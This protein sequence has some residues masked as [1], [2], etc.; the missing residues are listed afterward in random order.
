MGDS[1]N[2]KFDAA[3]LHRMFSDISEDQSLQLNKYA[4]LIKEHQQRFQLV[5]RTDIHRLM[6]NH[7]IPSLIAP[8][9]I[10]IPPGITMIDIG[11]GAGLPAIPIKII[12]PDLQY[13]LVESAR[14]KTLFL[15]KT[16]ET[17][18]L[19]GI[20]VLNFRLGTEPSPIDLTHKFFIVTA[21]AV[22]SLE[23][24]FLLSQSLLIGGGFMIFWKGEKDLAEL[25]QAAEKFRFSY[26]IFD[27]PLKYYQ[28]S[29]KLKTMKLFQIGA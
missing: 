21:R 29:A 22:T 16:V 9:I 10:D 12:R 6:E 2:Q 3:A 15:R 1:N 4:Q 14:K 28:F 8:Q 23:N 13:V 26:Q 17:L 19:S 18:H 27:P 25:R 20:H 24:L 5:S 11:S 7:I